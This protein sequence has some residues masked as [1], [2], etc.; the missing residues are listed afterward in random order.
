[1]SSA[2]LALLA[3]CALILLASRRA[4]PGSSRCGLAYWW[5]LFGFGYAGVIEVVHLDFP[6]GTGNVAAFV[7]F[8]P[9]IVVGSLLF[10]SSVLRGG[11]LGVAG[12]ALIAF[13][14]LSMGFVVTRDADY[15]PI[16]AFFAI[17]PAVSTRSDID[18]TTL[19]RGFVDSMTLIAV[20][21]IVL[22]V[23]APDAVLGPCRL[24]KCSLWGEQLGQMGDANAIGMAAAA[25][26]VIAAACLERRWLALPYLTGVAGIVDLASSRSALLPLAFGG[27]G[28]LA[29]RFLRGRIVSLI[30]VALALSIIGVQVYVASS[31]WNFDAF[32]GRGVLWDRAQILI[33]QSPLWGY[34][35]SFWV[36]QDATSAIVANYS[37]H[38]LI[39]ELLVSTGALGLA[40]VFLAVASAL[41]RR[42]GDDRGI[43]SVALLAWLASG[44]TEVMAAPGRLYLFP[45]LFPAVFILARVRAGRRENV[46][47]HEPAAAVMA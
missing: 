39:L 22:A 10:V 17:L 4:V 27:A 41:R 19:R 7:E 23:R 32:T 21:L 33:G 34:G 30:T 6:L 24:D 16:V 42:T 5:V 14:L 3:S 2:Y 31:T 8:G 29:T 12:L 37:S 13:G 46:E 26:G 44:V 15:M 35:P 25:T 36:R 11:Y 18:L 47:E 38:N 45:A 40:L 20:A 43:L 9:A 1:M 28:V